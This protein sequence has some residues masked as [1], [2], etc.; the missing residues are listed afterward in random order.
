MIYPLK[1]RRA[2]IAGHCGMVGSAILRQ[3]SKEDCVILTAEREEL[4]LRN[5]AAVDQWFARYG[6]D[7]VFLAAARV[8]GIHENTTYPGEFL[9]DNLAIATNVIEASRRTGVRKLMFL[10]SSCIY[11]RLAAQPMQE[12]CLLT[13][14]LEPTNQWYA[15]AKI[16]GLKLCQAYRRQH[17]CDFVSVMPTNLYGPNDNFELISSHVLP[18]LITKID[19]AARLGRPS[20]TIWG[21]GTPRREFLHVD[22]LADAVVFLMQTWSEEE[23]LNIGTGQDITILELAHTIA[24]VIGYKGEFV[25]DRSKPDGAPRKLLDVS[26][27]ASLGWQPC[28]DLE[29]GI[30]RTYEWYRD[31]GRQCDNAEPIESGSTPRY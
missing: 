21:S 17:A 8:G 1:G 6:P 10:G 25:L 4:D 2:F 31:H 18:A 11:P 22:D 24:G 7:T 30:R 3:L 14:S 26:K 28:I 16:A 13:G 29:T 20:V 5:Q 12:S 9:Y 15:V 23:P 19:A 27:L